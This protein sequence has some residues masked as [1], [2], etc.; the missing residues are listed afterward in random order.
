LSRVSEIKQG[1][2]IFF[3]KNSQ[4]RKRQDITHGNTRSHFNFFLLHSKQEIVGLAL[5]FF[6]F[7]NCSSPGVSVDAEFGLWLGVGWK[8]GCDAMVFVTLFLGYYF[9]RF[10]GDRI[11]NE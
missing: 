4:L 6:G 9:G 2:F 5:L 1:N 3:I 7:G 10:K 11:G 8:G